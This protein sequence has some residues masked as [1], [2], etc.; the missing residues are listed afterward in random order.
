MFDPVS[1]DRILIVDLKDF[2]IR[3]CHSVEFNP[4]QTII[5]P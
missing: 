5:N 2:V 4:N 3:Y 1:H